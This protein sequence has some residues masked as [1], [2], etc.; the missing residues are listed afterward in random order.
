MNAC[1]CMPHECISPI[2]LLS[3]S[4]TTHH[5]HHRGALFLGEDYAS[6]A[7]AQP[8]TGGDRDSTRSDSTAS[9]I[10][11]VPSVPSP[12]RDDHD[13]LVNMLGLASD[14]YGGAGGYTI[15]DINEACYLFLYMF[16]I[17][18]NGHRVVH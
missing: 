16:G 17:W 18:M 4:N 15:Y 13:D 11:S 9:T 5:R 3:P 6:N 10:P 2:P 8:N 14:Y 12:E 1:V 7:N